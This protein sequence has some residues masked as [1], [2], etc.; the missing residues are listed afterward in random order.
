MTNTDPTPVPFRPLTLTLFAV[1]RCGR[2]ARFDYDGKS[3]VLNLTILCDGI[4]ETGTTL[5]PGSS[6]M[7]ELRAGLGINEPD[8]T[9][10]TG[11]TTALTLR[12][13]YDS[14]RGGAITGD[15]E[16]TLTAH[17]VERISITLHPVENR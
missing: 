7:P 8:W 4:P 17:K 9:N 5:A 1:G 15:V 11:D 14:V 6:Y 13:P 2:D 3:D 10:W 16:Y 12:L